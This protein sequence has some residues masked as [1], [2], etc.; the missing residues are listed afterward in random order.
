MSCEVGTG[1]TYLGHSHGSGTYWYLSCMPE[2]MAAA[3]KRLEARWKGA[4]HADE[5]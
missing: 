5:R 4:R 3:G 2:L 1:S